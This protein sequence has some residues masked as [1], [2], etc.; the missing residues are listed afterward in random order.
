MRPRYQRAFQRKKKWSRLSRFAR[1]YPGV[2]IDFTRL[3]DEQVNG[4]WLNIPGLQATE[5]VTDIMNT[6][7]SVSTMLSGSKDWIQQL[8][9]TGWKDES[10]DAIDGI[11]R[12]LVNKLESMSNGRR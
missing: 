1:F 7:A 11:S 12:S 2:R 3:T 4:M 6:A 9:E 10:Q 5:S 8:A